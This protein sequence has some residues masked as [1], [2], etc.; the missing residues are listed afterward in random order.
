MVSY[1]AP[2]AQA[3][4]TQ[5]YP[6]AAATPTFSDPRSAA[7]YVQQQ[8]QLGQNLFLEDRTMR[9]DMKN[10]RK[11]IRETVKT[12]LREA[13]YPDYPSMHPPSPAGYQ[14]RNVPVISPE[15]QQVDKFETLDTYDDFSVSYTADGGIINYQARNKLKLDEER[16]LALRSLIR[17]DLAGI[18]NESKKK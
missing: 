9:N 2:S 14:F 13:S 7:A 10:L 15:A 16:Y 3:Q 12:E 1:Q 8:Q 17:Q 6:Q 5:M 18:I 11:F 4:Q